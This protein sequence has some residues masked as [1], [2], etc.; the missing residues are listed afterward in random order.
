VNTADDATTCVDRAT[1]PTCVETQRDPGPNG[2]LGDADDVLTPLSGFR[3]Q[4]EITDL[5]NLDVRALVVT[6]SYR[7]GP[8]QRTYVLRTFI[9]AFS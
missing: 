7:V 9:S 6:I 1:N 8:Q 5:A 3:R 2:V 4:I